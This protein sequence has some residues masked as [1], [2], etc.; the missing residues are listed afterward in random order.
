MG[1]NTLRSWERS[2]GPW[3]RG[4]RRTR[5]ARASDHLKLMCIHMVSSMMCAAIIYNSP[6]PILDKTPLKEVL[7]FMTLFVLTDHNSYAS[8]SHHSS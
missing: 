8:E 7:R 6:Y 2:G 3:R 1:G 4:G 5:A